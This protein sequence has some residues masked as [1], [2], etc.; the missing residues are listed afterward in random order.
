MSDFKVGDVLRYD[1]ERANR[2]CREGQA[3]V[4]RIEDGRVIAFDTYW[5]GTSDRHRLT[6][7]E[8]ASAEVEFN[9]AEVRPVTANDIFADFHPGDRKIVTHQHGLQQTR[10][11][12]LLAEPDLATQIQNAREK[13]ANCERE[14]K[15]AEWSLE[16]AQRIL[17]SLEGV[18][19]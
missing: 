17:E 1:S 2:W 3:I 11:L 14:L 10:Y 9:L 18:K 5:F 16:I 12:R 19:A 13:V 6:D 4:D 8:L 7:G 15:S